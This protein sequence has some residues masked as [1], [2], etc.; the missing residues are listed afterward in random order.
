MMK[1]E[2]G[3]EI[4]V[5]DTEALIYKMG[6]AGMEHFEQKESDRMTLAQLEAFR[7]A[8]Y[9]MYATAQG[10]L[11]SLTESTNDAKLD[12]RSEGESA[13]TVASNRK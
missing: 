8:A 13:S 2:N 11:D 12:G 3:N 1:D 5:N 9:R 4:Y 7:D 10:Y 6:R